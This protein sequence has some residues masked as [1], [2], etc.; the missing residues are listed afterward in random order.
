MEHHIS[1]LFIEDLATR[2]TKNTTC[3]YEVGNAQ[4]N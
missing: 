2:D 4:E 3:I 1:A